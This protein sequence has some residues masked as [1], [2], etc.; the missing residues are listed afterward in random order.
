[1]DTV[2][3]ESATG[4]SRSRPLAPINQ[5]K[6][7]RK[8]FAEYP[9]EAERNGWTGTVSFTVTVT[10]QGRATDCIVTA[11]SGYAV[12][13]IAA[14][15]GLTRHAR[16]APARDEQGKAVA[17]KWMSRITYSSR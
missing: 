2:P 4:R 6:W 7:V 8:I 14:C 16:F 17:G 5:I 11:S 15:E 13:D 9:A 1:M 12:M 10:P 3:P